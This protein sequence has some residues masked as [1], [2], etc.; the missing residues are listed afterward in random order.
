MTTLSGHWC[1][2]PPA[3]PA[4]YALLA[5]SLVL[6][7]P[8]VLSLVRSRVSRGRS[9][10]HATRPAAQ[11]PACLAVTTRRCNFPLQLGRSYYWYSV[12]WT[13]L[14]LARGS[15]CALWGRGAKTHVLRSRRIESSRAQFETTLL[16]WIWA[17]ALAPLT[18]ARQS[19]LINSRHI[20]L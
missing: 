1:C 16:I 10:G 7:F 20:F 3:S 13:D 17:G 5:V 6:S 4:P 15:S 9:H 2:E 18:I 19:Q 11:V 12:Y 8:R 14:V